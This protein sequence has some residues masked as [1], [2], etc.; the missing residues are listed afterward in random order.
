MPNQE[1]EQPGAEIVRGQFTRIREMSGR[2]RLVYSRGRC[3]PQ[4]PAPLVGALAGTSV[5]TSSGG[6]SY[7]IS[8]PR[9][10]SV[11]VDNRRAGR[12]DHADAPRRL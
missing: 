10:P 7:W 9:S 4:S 8:A 3:G 6:L 11:L 12:R 2:S 5:L 1:K